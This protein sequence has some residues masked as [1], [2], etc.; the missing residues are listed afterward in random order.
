MR[1]RRERLQVLPPDD[2]SFVRDAGILAA[3]VALVLAL[4]FAPYLFGDRSLLSGAIDASSTFA[5]GATPHDH[6][7][8]VHSLDAG[9]PAWQS[10]PW[11]ALEHRI[12]ADRRM[13]F[14]DPYDGYGAPFAAAMQPQPFYPLTTLVSL[15]P[16]PRAYNWFVVFR[17]FLAG[18]FAALYVRLFANRY[19]AA[20]TGVAT[21]LTG[22][23]LLYYNM[24]HLSVDVELPMLL[25]ATEIVVRRP[26]PR[27]VAALAV[28]AALTYLGGMPESALLSLAFGGL[29]GILRIATSQ[30]PL[31]AALGVVG[32]HATGLLLGAVMV[33]PFAD[34]VGRSLNQ[35]DPGT[36]GGFAGLAFDPGWRIG[37]LTELA[38]LAFG[39][40][41]ASI[42]PNNGPTGVRGFFGCAVLLLAVIAVLTSIRRRDE[43]LSVVAFLGVVAFYCI[44]KRYGNP[45]V[46]WTGA[47]PLFRLIGFPKYIEFCLGVAM[48]ILGGFGLAAVMERRAGRATLTVAAALTLALLT[49]L[50]LTTRNIPPP[51]P[52]I[53]RYPLAILIALCAL[54]GAAGLAGLAARLDARGRNFAAVG[55]TLVVTAE[56]VAGYA[57]PQLWSEM[58]PIADDPYAGAPYLTFLAQHVDRDRERIF[59]IGGVLFPNWAGAYGFADPRGLNAL[60]PREYLPFIN[61]FIAR[62]GTVVDDQ[63]DR[64]T[65]TN[66]IQLAD[67][68]VQRWLALSSVRWLLTPRPIEDIAPPPGAFLDALWKQTAPTVPENLAQLVHPTS[69]RIDGVS[70]DALF[71]HPP[72]DAVR[73]TAPIPADRPV[74]AA[75]VA[76]D[77]LTYAHEPVCGGPVTFTL[78]AL[79]GTISIATASR[80]IDP[81]HVRAERRWLP[82]RLDLS[83]WRGREVTL[84]F[85]TSAADLCAPWAL[86]GEPRFARVGD[87]AALTGTHRLFE[88]TF[89]S[90]EA[91]VYHLEH[92]LPRLTLFH[93]TTLAPNDEAARA[94]L[95]E[96]AFDI[97]R[98]VTVDRDV[99]LGA[100]T[101]PESVTITSVHSDELDAVVTATAPALLMQNDALVPGWTATV[102]GAAVPLVRADALFRGVSVPAGRH[103]VTIAYR[104]AAD[105]IGTLAALAGIVVLAALLVA[106][107]KPR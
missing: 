44:L 22:Y 90:D 78:E 54:A 30:A 13:P 53:W 6:A 97:R 14:W 49:Y 17:L 64:F 41:W 52:E 83:R 56:L 75:D 27:S 10:E 50:Y 37:L 105:R 34:Y 84:R 26:S 77:P 79:L 43:R 102:D 88:P 33:V 91:N 25:W 103:V 23:Y 24:P 107:P 101:G 38:P 70:E 5:G 16:T 1:R 21:A 76:L 86:W 39:H 57:G 55:L 87:G 40:P 95:T 2:A 106:K 82:F 11:L 12:L 71:E 32:G 94:L 104:P 7:S 18:W 66:P 8:R 73:Y 85:A 9:A 99:P 19:A 92:A 62:A 48:A 100:R 65:G 47:L 4:V 68:L 74:V 28:A 69:A 89:A 36:V 42:L 63:R 31:R 80:T 93:Q 20:L 35:H 29:Y 98:T 46:N 72:Y 45:A 51:G 61:A 58:A 67:P 60:Y 3:V 15:H 59:G 96:P 81:K